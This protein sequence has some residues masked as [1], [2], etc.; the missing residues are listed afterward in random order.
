MNMKFLAICVLGALAFS[1]GAHAQLKA[2]Y[3]SADNLVAPD[4]LGAPGEKIEPIKTVFYVRESFTGFEALDSEKAKIKVAPNFNGSVYVKFES[5]LV[6][7]TI[8]AALMAKGVKIANSFEEADLRITGQGLYRVLLRPY[9]QRQIRFNAT[10]DQYKKSASIV[11]AESK[12]IGAGDALLRGSTTAISKGIGSA[13]FLGWLIE[14]TMDLTGATSAMERAAGWNEKQR[15]EQSITFGDC[16]DST[17]RLATCAPGTPRNHA[18]M[19][20]VRIQYVD[21]HTSVSGKNI[22]ESKFNL[23]ARIIDGRAETKDDMNEL[24]SSAIQELTSGF[25][26]LTTDATKATSNEAAQ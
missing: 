4:K 17:T 26:T 23:V 8:N 21:F 15:G 3:Y 25:P 24:L 20:R 7:Q 10:F 22:E 13:A 11:D 2:Q 12:K 18:Y 5:D 6:N 1:G 16:Y 19:Q 14:S 9:L